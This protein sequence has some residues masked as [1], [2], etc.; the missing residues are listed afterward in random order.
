TGNVGARDIDTYYG[1]GMN[2]IVAKPIDPDKLKRI[3]LRAINDATANEVAEQTS[4]DIS[5]AAAPEET[6]LGYD[7]PAFDDETLRTLKDNLSAAQLE[8]LM[9]GALDKTD[10]IIGQMQ[11][12]LTDQ[13]IDVLKAKGHELKG[14]AGNFGMLELSTIAG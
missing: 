14:M 9:Q 10:E 11:A 3:I 4:D 12:A 7:L 1:V 13:K 6:D 8:E 5:P 2:G